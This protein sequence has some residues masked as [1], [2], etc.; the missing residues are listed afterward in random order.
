M[1]GDAVTGAP[2]DA[3]TVIAG[4]SLQQGAELV[5]QQLEGVDLSQVA[6]VART[7]RLLRLVAVELATRGI[8]YQG[9]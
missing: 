1:L 7:S 3:V 6:V 8:G 2:A 9:P 5:A 4:E